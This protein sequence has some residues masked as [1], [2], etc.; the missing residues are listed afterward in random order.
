MSGNFPVARSIMSTDLQ[1]SELGTYKGEGG[2]STRTRELQ[3][4]NVE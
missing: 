3:N 4:R 2:V 1:G